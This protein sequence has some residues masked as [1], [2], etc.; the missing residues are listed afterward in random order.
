MKN[1]KAEFNN[2]Q[3]LVYL[4]K[5]T[6]SKTKKLFVYVERIEQKFDN[7]LNYLLDF[8]SLVED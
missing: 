4:S 7:A 1:L 2:I 8:N 6:N 5:I 3:K